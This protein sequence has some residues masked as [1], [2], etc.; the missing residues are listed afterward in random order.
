DAPRFAFSVPAI[1]QE[2]PMQWYHWRVLPQGMKN[3]PTICQ[4]YVA[5]ILSPI[6]TR[7]G[8]AIIV[9]Y[10]D[11]V[12]VCCPNDTYLEWTLKMVIDAL[13]T[14]GFELQPEKAQKTSPWRYLGLKITKITMPQELMASLIITGSDKTLVQ[15]QLRHG[16]EW[17][18]VTGMTYA[19]ADMTVTPTEK[20]PSQWEL[21]PQGVVSGIGGTQ[22]ARQSKMVGQLEGPDGLIASIPPFVLDTKFTLWGYLG[23][24]ITKITM[25]QE[26]MASLIIT[27]RACLRILA[28]CDFL[29][30][31]LPI[32]MD[33]LEHM[34]QTNIN[35]QFALDS[36]SGQISNHRPKHKFFNEAF[37][38]IPREV[39]SRKPLKNALTIFTDGS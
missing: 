26:L 22:L 16:A 6:C 11:D 20:W 13:E 39:Q 8:K 14:W 15:C 25:P 18:N 24:K 17:F 32:V 1:N 23:L 28:G 34:V 27:G 29:C 4:W 33:H 9:H 37:F 35:F 3:R 10:M 19:G 30:I 5:K 31:Y 21:Q 7:V 2:A 38:I 12:L 36:Y